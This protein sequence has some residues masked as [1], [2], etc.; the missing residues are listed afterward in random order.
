[1]PRSLVDR[2]LGLG[3]GRHVAAVGNAL[4]QAHVRSVLG[5]ARCPCKAR[6]DW[7]SMS[8]VLALARGVLRAKPLA[9]PALPDSTAQYLS[10]I[11]TQVI[12]SVQP[13][14]DEPPRAPV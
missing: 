6:L 8:G 4:A 11:V 1:M 7:T 3:I 12:P 13:A 5:D 14:A 9:L 2:C 10:V